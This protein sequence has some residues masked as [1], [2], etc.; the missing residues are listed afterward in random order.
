MKA[1]HG[2]FAALLMLGF[3]SLPMPARADSD[4]QKFLEAIYQKYAGKDA[5]GVALDGNEMLLQYFTPELAAMIAFDADRSQKNDEP[6]VLD[7]DPFVGAQDWDIKD[8]SVAVKDTGPDKAV[9]T[10]VF[11]NMGEKQSVEL[12]LKKLP[13]GWRVDEI[14]WAD[15]SLRDILKGDGGNS[16]DDK[17]LP[18][19]RKL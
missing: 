16:D 15:G 1:I 10:A 12:D 6:P 11:T 19:T 18:E 5:A 4:A 14:R 7:G 9:G 2:F 13:Q 17:E 3:A 8:V